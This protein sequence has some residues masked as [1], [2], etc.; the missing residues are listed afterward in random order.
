M[1]NKLILTILTS[2]LTGPSYAEEILGFPNINWGDSIE[3]VA[4]NIPCRRNNI[5]MLID[6]DYSIHYRDINNVTLICERMGKSEFIYT[7]NGAEPF[8]ASFN[9]SG[10]YK[11]TIGS[12]IEFEDKK[13]AETYI[14]SITKYLDDIY[15]EPVTY[16]QNDAVLKKIYKNGKVEFIIFPDNSYTIHFYPNGMYKTLSN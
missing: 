5:H 11:I 3:K 12:A 15:G 14:E 4:Q 1:K 7:K 16:R 8:F 2:L 6:N 13:K 10:L 9:K